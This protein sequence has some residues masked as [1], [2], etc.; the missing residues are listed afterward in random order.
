MNCTGDGD[1]DEYDAATIFRCIFVCNVR[2]SRSVYA[3]F[4]K[5]H[6]SV[7][8]FSERDRFHTRDC[9][10][11]FSSLFVS[12]FDQ[13]GVRLALLSARSGDVIRPLERINNSQQFSYTTVTLIKGAFCCDIQ[14]RHAGQ[15]RLGITCGTAIR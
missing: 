15:R 6:F 5:H 14:Q 3:V 9:F 12:K 2:K 13:R 1:N 8:L 11:L 7:S 10:I 4:S